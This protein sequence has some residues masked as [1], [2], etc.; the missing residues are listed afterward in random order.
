MP[1]PNGKTQTSCEL[2]ALEYWI[3]N[4]GNMA[5]IIRIQYKGL[6]SP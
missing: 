4:K 2:Q 3:S 6:N 5:C 1:K